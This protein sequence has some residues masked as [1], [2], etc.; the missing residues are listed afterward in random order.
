MERQSLTII[1]RKWTPLFQPNTDNIIRNITECLTLGKHSVRLCTHEHRGRQIN[2]YFSNLG[3]HENDLRK[4]VK[5]QIPG[6]GSWDCDS[7][8]L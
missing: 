2:S 5:T 7:V 4:L 3:M 6:Y 1:Y 8:G